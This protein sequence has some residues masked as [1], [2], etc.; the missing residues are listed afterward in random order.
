MTRDPKKCQFCGDEFTPKQA[1]SI[2]CEKADCKK[3]R[4]KSW[5]LDHYGNYATRKKVRGFGNEPQYVKVCECCC[6]VFKPTHGSVIWCNKPKCQRHKRAYQTRKARKS[7][8]V[9]NKTLNNSL[10]P[11]HGSEL[12]QFIENVI[13]TV[14]DEHEQV[15]LIFMEAAS[16]RGHAASIFYPG[17]LEGDP[18][19][20]YRMTPNRHRK[21][22]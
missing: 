8:T 18:L 20:C 6:Q 10:V 11:V 3:Q 9:R 14:F 21:S 16:L 19:G 2:T 12:S 7:S 22:A 4:A 1:R 15:E 17:I 5:Y 13:E